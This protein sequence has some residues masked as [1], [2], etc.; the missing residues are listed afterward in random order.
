MNYFMAFAKMKK[1]V[2]LTGDGKMLFRAEEVGGGNSGLTREND[3]NWIEY[4][5]K[6]D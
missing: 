6:A 1:T 3:L 2:L 4:K 5:L